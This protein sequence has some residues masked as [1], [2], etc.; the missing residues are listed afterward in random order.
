MLH[1]PT[2]HPTIGGQQL[3]KFNK[4]VYNYRR[5]RE[6]GKE[7]GGERGE[8]AAATVSLPLSSISTPQACV[9]SPLDEAGPRWLPHHPQSWQELFTRQ[10]WNVPLTPAA[11]SFLCLSFT[12]FTHLTYPWTR[13]PGTPPLPPRNPPQTPVGLAIQATPF[14]LNC[15]CHILIAN[16]NKCLNLVSPNRL[17]TLKNRNQ[18]FPIQFSAS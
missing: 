12:P 1:F 3:W 2:L 6:R 14:A 17:Q 8:K 16:S 18:V 11:W 4:C 7:G 9:I 13:P 5:R 15:Y 10:T